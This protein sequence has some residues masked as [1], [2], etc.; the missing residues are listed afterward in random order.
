VKSAETGE[1]LE[2]PKARA[3]HDWRFSF[4]WIVPVLA[5]AFVGWLVYRRVIAKGPTITIRFRDAEG[6]QAG[7][8]VLRFRG[9]TLGNVKALKLSK[10]HQSVE[11]EVGLEKSAEDLAREG[12]EFWIVKPS[13][14]ASKIQGLGTIV[15]GDF[16]TIRP[17]TGKPADHFVGLEEAPVEKTEADGL[18]IVLLASKL[19]SLERGSPIFYRGIQVGE[20][21]NY[22][23]GS[24][25]QLVKI[26]AIIE[27]HYEP[28]VRM[29]TV[30]W[31]AGGINVNIGLFGAAISAHSFQSLISGGIAMATP[32]TAEKEA[33]QGTTYRL[34]EKPDEKWLAWEPAIHL[35]DE[36]KP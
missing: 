30:F 3:A 31:N 22:E 4:I 9:A 27:P 21:L 11:V 26:S 14:S 18:K 12:S 6:L 13:V 16:I 5:L 36:T 8:S 34:Y 19:S 1:E 25:S 29:N 7:N 35:K 20:V 28:L 17:G 2:L 23:L 32:N 10:D 15:S 33:P 24:D